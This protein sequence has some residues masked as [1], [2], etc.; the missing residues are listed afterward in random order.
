VKVNGIPLNPE[1]G[2]FSVRCAFGYDMETSEATVEVARPPIGADMW[3]PVTIEMGATRETAQLRFAGYLIGLDKTFYPRSCSLICRGY[4]FKAKMTAPAIDDTADELWISMCNDGAGMTDEDQVEAI[5][6]ACG[7]TGVARDI[8]GT[9]KLL[10]TYADDQFVW[11]DGES[12]LAYIHRLE[13][14]CLGYR[15]FD[16]LG[17]SIVRRRI[18]AQPTGTPIATF[19]EGVDI[20]DGSYSD[21]ILEI[22]NRVHVSGYGTGA[23]QV[24]ITVSQSTPY[25]PNGYITQVVSNGMIERELTADTGDGLSCEE[26]GRWQLAELNRRLRKTT[27]S[28]PRDDMV[29]PGATI[30]IET[31]DRFG[32]AQPAWVQ[33]VEVSIGQDGAFT[34]T[35]TAIGGL[36]IGGEVNVPDPNPIADFAFIALEVESVIEGG[37]PT[38]LYTVR[39]KAACT[40][41]AAPIASYAW[42]ASAG[43]VPS[44]GT[45]QTFQ[46]SFADPAGAT[47]TLAATDTA[48]N[49]GTVTKPLPTSDL[50][51]GNW[52]VRKIYAAGGSVVEVYT[53]TGWI[54]LAEPS[55]TAVANGPAWQSGNN[56]VTSTDDLATMPTVTTPFTGVAVTALDT[57]IPAGLAHVLVGTADGRLAYSS[58]SGATWTQFTGP[59]GDVNPVTRVWLSGVPGDWWCLTAI[60]LYRTLDSGATWTKVLAAAAG[61]SFQDAIA[62]GTRTMVAMSGG[63]VLCDVAG[64]AQTLPAGMTDL[65]AAVADPESDVFYCYD[66]TGRTCAHDAS[67]GTT[68]SER[69]ALPGGTPQLRGLA[70]DT[71]FPGLLYVATGAGGIYKSL[72]GFATADGYKQ[73]RAP[74]TDG[75]PAG[76]A[77]AQVG[78]GKLVSTTFTG[79]RVLV[80]CAGP[81]VFWTENIFTAAPVWQE[82]S[83]GLPAGSASASYLRL[84]P[85]NFKRGF[86]IAGAETTAGVVYK[87]DDI[88]GGGAWSPI[89]TSA[90]AISAIG[91]FEGTTAL[92]AYIRTLGLSSA[93][94]NLIYA[95]VDVR[96]ANWTVVSKI[97]L[98]KSLD[99]GASWTNLG[100]L[101]AGAERHTAQ[102]VVSQHDASYIVLVY[103]DAAGT[104]HIGY[105]ATGAPPLTVG[106]SGA[107]GWLQVP[108]GGNDA[109]QI[110]Y[111]RGGANKRTNDGGQTWTDF[112]TGTYQPFVFDDMIPDHIMALDSYSGVRY[113]VD[114]GLTW[115]DLLKPAPFTFRGTTNGLAISFP[116]TEVFYYCGYDQATGNT[117]LVSTL[118]ADHLTWTDRTGNLPV[119][120][121]CLTVDPQV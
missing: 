117:W 70:M 22:R 37:A 66:S 100:Q 111:Y 83:N 25:V 2:P 69:V 98:L 36:G 10:G 71:E 92:Q 88:I 58:D 24:K 43:G 18:F 78:A 13:E 103:T 73:I 105:S 14:I 68:L 112:G 9:G 97:F 45:G 101:A 77:Y 28:T 23:G 47:V 80:S 56:A 34:Q 84:D 20:L 81:R 32:I 49:V 44:S 82:N 8:Q 48:G 52:P 26:V 12:G 109:D 106:Y 93:L 60:G 50:S 39:C 116:S 42:T 108:Y 95:V 118:A 29:P 46:V 90:D 62:G 53:V 61:E 38:P 1:Y 67:G 15:T 51:S 11:R 19:R 7:L 4:L 33:K 31:S 76:A 121:G 54:S 115:G 6:D 63:R 102:F 86:V 59:V 110:A 96:P 5:L 41:I 16:G 87:N 113:S 3:S 89:L 55:A 65:Y 57:D 91:T 74:G 40:P 119:S 75:S 35:I 30:Q 21:T 114:R 120:P 17:G 107:G 79:R 72:D 64:V 104:Y 94:E 85:W 99:G 27:F